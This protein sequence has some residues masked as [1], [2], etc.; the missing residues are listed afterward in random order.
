M[1]L[2]VAKAE[3]EKF[4][5]VELALHPGS[6][7]HFFLEHTSLWSLL[8]AVVI[9]IAFVAM[10]GYAAIRSPPVIASK[11]EYYRMN[12]TNE[13]VSIDVEITLNQ[14]IPE[15]RFVSVNGSLVTNDTTTS[16]VLPI[17]LTVHKTTQKNFVAVESNFHEGR[18]RIDLSFTAGN[19]RSSSFAVTRVQARDIDTLQLRLSLGTHYKSIA[20]FLFRWEFGN[21][22]AEKYDQSSKL[23]MSFLVGYM[24]VVFAFYLRFDSELFTQVLLIV[25]GVTGV[26]AANPLNYFVKAQQRARIIDH[27]LMAVFIAVFRLFVILGLELIRTHS[28][29][30]PRTLVAALAVV[31]AFYATL[32]AAASYDR[33]SHLQHAENEVKVIFKTEAARVLFDIVFAVGSVGYFVVAAVANEGANLRRVIY[34]GIVVAAIASTTFISHVVFLATG[35]FMYTLLP[36]MLVCSTHVTFAAITLFLLHSAGGPAYKSLETQAKEEQQPMGFEDASDGSGSSDDEE[37]SDET[38]E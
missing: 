17:D 10:H 27:T 14:L 1:T 22:I 35:A 9:L 33:H 3:S 25:V 7:S 11:E 37:E 29:T 16:R 4:S 23:L 36:D 32:D 30:P 15:H 28:Q 2:N 19:N 34:F 24:L 38:E 6:G 18:R 13:N 5:D 8:I 12:A 26:F 21:S 20:G 31:F